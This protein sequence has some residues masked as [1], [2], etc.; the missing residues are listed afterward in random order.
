ML[1]GLSAA[2]P[3]L[4][5]ALPDAPSLVIWT[6][7]CVAGAPVHSQVHPKLFPALWGVPKLMA[8]T[9]MVLLYQSSKILVTPKA[10]RNALLGSYSLLKLTH[11]RLHSTSSQTL[12]E[13]RRDWNTFSWWVPGFMKSVCLCHNAQIGRDQVMSNWYIPCGKNLEVLG[14]ASAAASSCRCSPAGAKQSTPHMVTEYR[15]TWLWCIPVG[16][17]VHAMWFWSIMLLITIRPSVV[18]YHVRK[19]DRSNLT[20]DIWQSIC[21]ISWNI[22]GT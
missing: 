4:S 18:R 17:H 6:P 2:L 12:P 13:A 9:T 3:G 8:I 5:S 11:R 20:L 10:G 7:V 14:I 22:T 21:L 15:T 19:C 16:Y 1:P